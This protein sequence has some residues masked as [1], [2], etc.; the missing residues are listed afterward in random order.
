MDSASPSEKVGE[1]KPNGDA[2]LPV[3]LDI[4][5]ED[6][7]AIE[8]NEAAEMTN[9]KHEEVEEA[10]AEEIVEEVVTNGKPLGGPS[11]KRMTLTHGDPLGALDVVVDDIP[12]AK[13]C[14]SDNFAVTPDPSM[15]L[16]ADHHSS[17]ESED[18]DQLYDDN[19]TPKLSLR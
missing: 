16:F 1:S 8:T 9:G 10:I 18:D 19:Q 15:R 5:T 11:P 2:P 6:S 17:E 14:I 4:A 7:S 3:P 13:V 12:L